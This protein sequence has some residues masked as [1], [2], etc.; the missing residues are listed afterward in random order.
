MPG[1]DAVRGIPVEEPGERLRP[2]GVRQFADP[3]VVRVPGRTRVRGIPAHAD[4]PDVRVRRDGLVGP[5]GE[6]VRELLRPAD[7]VGPGVVRTAVRNL[8]VMDPDAL[9]GRC[10]I[11]GCDG[12]SAGC[13]PRGRVR[14]TP[15]SRGDLATREGSG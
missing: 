14:K 15:G 12:R 4:E 1:R 3:G 5:D 10:R 2:D 8:P 7:L 13:R 9:H 11:H 6:H